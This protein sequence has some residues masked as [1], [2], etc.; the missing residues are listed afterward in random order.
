V[1]RLIPD[2][3]LSVTLLI[4]W[5]AL[6]S[7]VHP[8]TILLGI[9]C[10]VLIPLAVK[11]LL[12]ERYDVKSWRTLL[13][14]IPLFL[15]DVVLANLAV[16]R[17]VLGARLELRPAWLVIPLDVTHPYAITMLASVISLTPG[18]VS[19]EL[20]EGR[21]TLLVHAL[22][23]EDAEAEVARIKSRYEAPIKEIFS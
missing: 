10:A 16:A 22:D 4:V 14:F 15:W 6:V 17:L 8:R 11:P 5:L 9:A 12:P 20:G 1:R 21:R 19:A 23:V 2:A 13:R 18:T 3:G 7:D